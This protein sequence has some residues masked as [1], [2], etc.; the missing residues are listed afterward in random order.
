MYNTLLIKRRLAS[1]P[2]NTIPVLS[3]GE[4]AFSEKN[5]TL[6]YGSQTGTLT[7]GGEGAFVT[8]TTNQT[9]TGSKTFTNL[10]TLSST[11][12]SPSSVINFGSNKIT[13]IGAPQNATDAVSKQYVDAIITGSI[14]GSF[15]DCTTTQ[16]ISGIK[17]FFDNA[18]FK[19]DLTVFSNISGSW[20]TSK[21]IDF[22]IDCGAF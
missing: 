8:T 5:D 13:N 2:L 4:L 12:F 11:T 6:Y 16:T 1:S 9:V 17:T 20:G 19:Q 18:F 22:I 3:G 14:S 7:I 15:V 21:L 10:T